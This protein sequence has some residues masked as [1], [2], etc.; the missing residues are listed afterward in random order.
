MSEE[1][2]GERVWGRKTK[3][4]KK[5]KKK[6]EKDSPVVELDARERARQLA[7][8]RDPRDRRALVEQERRAEQ[9]LALLLDQA[10]PQDLALLL[11]GHELRRQHL[12][13]DVRELLLRVDELVKVGLARLDRR[14]DR[15]ER[16]AALGHVALDLPRE[17]DLVRDVEVDLEVEQVA[18]ALVVEGVQALDD[19]DLGGLDPLR[20][21]EEPGHVVVDGLVDGLALAQRLDLLVH[22][23]EVLAALVE[24]G[25]LLDL[26]AVAV[27]GV[28]V[29][30]ADDGGHVGDE[31][32]GVGVAAWFVV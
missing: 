23:V 16:V 22:E 2:S 32:V 19:E 13:D 18:H 8:A 5:K 28:V 15:L 7:P 25:D 27:V 20:R 11:V 4:K 3:K 6:N 30:E 17:L 14:L 29:V 10:H 24:R 12:D 31:G 9:L 26:A 21:V 1:K